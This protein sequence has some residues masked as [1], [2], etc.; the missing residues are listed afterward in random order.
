M[1]DFEAWVINVESR[2]ERRAAMQNRLDEKGI[3]FKF[4]TAVEPKNLPSNQKLYLTDTAEA[5]W[6][7]HLECLKSASEATFPTLIMED[8][9]ILNIDSHELQKLADRMIIEK[10]D[11]IQIGFL[12]INLAD[13]ISIWL[14]NTY[15]FFTRNSQAAGVF[16]FFGFKEVSRAKAQYWRQGLPNNFVVNDVRYGAHCYLVSPNF[17]SDLLPLNSPAFLAADD[18]FVALSRMKTY[19]MI[20][21][22]KS[23]SDQDGSTSSFTQRFLLK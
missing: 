11:L 10:L 4:L 8:D 5:V 18:F 9:A 23:L 20:R 6:K 2:L 12:R 16:H 7:S 15:S 3:K 1:G 13:S 22:K 19:K 17:A 21:L 14:R